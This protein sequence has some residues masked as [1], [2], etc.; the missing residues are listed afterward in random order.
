MLK[1]LADYAQDHGLCAEPGF[2]PKPA[3]W[4]IDIGPDGS[5]LGII[6]LGDASDKKNRGEVFLRAP[7]FSFPQMKAGGIPKSH[8][9]I[10]TV[11][12]VALLGKDVDNPK[13]QAKHLYFIDLLSKAAAEVPELGLAAR[14][15]ADPEGL[16]RIQERLTAL[17]AKP[18]DKITVRI[19]RQLP[20]RSEGWHAWWRAF[21]PTVGAPAGE[22]TDDQ[23][24]LLDA[25]ADEAKGKPSAPRMRCLIS[26]EL[27]EPAV[28]HPKIQGLTDVG[29]SSMGGV[30][31]GFDKDAFAS[32]GLSQSANA[33]V[34]EMAAAAYR[35]GLNDVID[36][37]SR[38]LAGAKV[39]H[40]Y[41]QA[42]PA[43]ADPVNFLS[44]AW[45][46]DTAE[47]DAQRRAQELLE[48]VRSGKRPD[49][50]DNHYYALTLS[51][52]SGRVMVRD[53]ME[54]PFE[55]LVGN[56]LAW[57]SD[58][59]IVRRDG[60]GLAPPPKFLAV[61]GATVRE[62]DDLAAPM[63]TKLWK[64]A[65]A[66]EPVP[67]AAL[68]QAVLRFRVDVIDDSPLNH[69]RMGLIRMY[70]VRK[71]NGDTMSEAATPYLNEDHPSPAYHCGRLM[72]VLARLQHA[73]LGDVGA[74]VV[75]RYYAAAS[76]T[77]SLVL[78]RLT[79]TAQFHLG[80][81]EPRLAGWYDKQLGQ[82]WGKLEGSVPRVLNLE[83]QSLF[84]MGYYQQLAYRAPKDIEPQQD[85]ESD[86]SSADGAD[87]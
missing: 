32:Y 3:R 17:K 67:Q 39:A 5:F 11:D 27:V 41:K 60:S 76:S 51:G 31:V 26:G 79:K 42:V 82:V 56:V 18:T 25:T 8:F 77:P 83:E 84:A 6:E 29:G 44:G 54:G 36:K 34:G 80:K 68:A 66:K 35:A 33:P 30:L 24:P 87:Q 65:I 4:A 43:E 73:A 28:T 59:Q 2:A 53:W 74:G 57:F 71:G 55:Q 50:A 47:L 1:Q 37:H 48:S 49:L 78:G 9:L 86:N 22:P 52:A 23:L 69:A 14:C 81:L 12:V 20:A 58:L 64:V 16:Q 62:L 38:R 70:H 85:T 10:D 72:A 75:Q 45:G 21:R 46:D 40:W 7:E 63:V 19:D 61:L 13:T 15:L